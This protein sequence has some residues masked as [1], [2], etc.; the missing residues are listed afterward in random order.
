MWVGWSKIRENSE[1]CDVA[2]SFESQLFRTT[3]VSISLQKFNQINEKTRK[4]C[5]ETISYIYKK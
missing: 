2:D 5:I 4:I 3:L 1:K